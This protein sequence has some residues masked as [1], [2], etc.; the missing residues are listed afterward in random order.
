MFKVPNQ[1]YTADFRALAVQRVKDGNGVR[2]VARELGISHQSLRNWVKAD[3]AGTLN[4]TGSKR[5]SRQNR[6]SFPV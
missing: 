6:W 4:G 3:A 5:L 2:D 1:S